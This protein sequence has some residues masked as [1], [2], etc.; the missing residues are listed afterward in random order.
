[1]TLLINRVNTNVLCNLP[2][3]LF[4]YLNLANIPESNSI[5]IESKMLS[6]SQQKNAVLFI[7][8]SL[9]TGSNQVMI[10]LPP[11]VL[12]SPMPCTRFQPNLTQLTGLFELDCV[13][14]EFDFHPSIK[15]Y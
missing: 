10:S 6:S 7:F 13:L 15:L 1:M 5:L 14:K 3:Y 12:V 11:P 4:P 2:N 9:C 8:V